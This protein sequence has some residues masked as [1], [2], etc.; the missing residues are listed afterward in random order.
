MSE[1]Q[2]DERFTR[3]RAKP[4]CLRGD[5]HDCRDAYIPQIYPICLCACHPIGRNLPDAGA[6]PP[7]RARA[8][9][10]GEGNA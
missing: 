5:H 1:A 3:A 7:P 4:E 9:L 2:R 6:V 8:A 10:D